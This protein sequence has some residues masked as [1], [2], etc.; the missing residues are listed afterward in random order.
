MKQS[1]VFIHESQCVS[2]LTSTSTQVPFLEWKCG[3]W[4]NANWIGLIY[5]YKC[6]YYC[7]WMKRIYN[8]NNNDWTEVVNSSNFIGALAIVIFISVLSS[9]QNEWMKLMV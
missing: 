6:L 7:L 2:I 3:F 5:E 8:D 9:R 1:H 4:S